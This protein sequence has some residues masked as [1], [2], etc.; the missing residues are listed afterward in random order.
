L[1]LHGA[2]MI[3]AVWLATMGALWHV[4]HETVALR[5]GRMLASY[6]LLVGGA[7]AALV[8]TLVGGFGAGWTFLPPLPFYAVGQWGRWSEVLFFVAMLLVGTGMAVFCLDVLQQVTARYDGLAGALGWRFLR[9]R[10]SEA[11]PPQVI[12]ATVIAID[13]LL[14]MAAGTAIVAGL[15]GRTYDS[16]VGFDV[17]VA[18]NL[19]Y[20]FGHTIANLV[21]YM[22][23][24]A[25]YV[26]L[27]RYAGRPYEVT[28]VFVGAWLVAAVL[29]VAVFSHHL[30]MD[31]VQPRWAE[32]TSSIASYSSALPVAVVTIYSMTM[33]VWGSRYR[34]TLA[35]TLLYLGLAGWAIGGTGA[36]IDSVIPINFRFHN[37]VWVVAHFHTYLMLT[38]V[39]WILAFLVHLLERDSGT[40]SS[41][42]ARATAIALLLVG[43]YGLTAT[44][45][46]AGVLGVPRRYA[47]QPPGTAGYSLA[48][49]IFA[50][51]FALGFVVCLLQ[52][53][54]LVRAAR[55][56]RYDL[57][58]RHTSWTGRTYIARRRRGVEPQPAASS[59]L[60]RRGV[61]LVG[62]AQLA[63]AAALCVVGLATFFPAVVHA[64][65]SSVRYHHLDHAGHFAFGLLLGL[66]LGSLPAV[67][68]RL[69]ERPTLGIVAVSVAPLAMMLV[70]VP[71]FY[72]PLEAHPFE[73]ALF[74]L[75]MAA[76]GLVTGLGVTRLGLVTGRFAAFLSVGMAVVFAAAMKGG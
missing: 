8:A 25:V 61:P 15:L 19:V 48:G 39:L 4:L 27:P 17:L 69:G 36:V 33:L 47:I 18:K 71:R 68:R 28:K 45:F 72:E 11:P 35:S 10:D 70:M 50:C 31:F 29:I 22:V 37:T 63:A 24:A 44:W 26:L 2:G 57:V 53:V 7:L 6:V 65:D 41:R 54:P 40:T 38:V 55:E 23:G 49:S 64:A 20:F 9:G 62:G 30:Y 76:L 51:V 13:G 3:T 60:P 34:W 46:V 73:H 14:A 59:P 42:G 66:L 56:R 32:V 67:S 5:V 1:T 43:G 16:G 74:H 52:L 58:E 75:G 21:I 12:A